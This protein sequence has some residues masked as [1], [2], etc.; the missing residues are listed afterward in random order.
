[1]G[2]EPGRQV[3]GKERVVA[4]CQGGA[5]GGGPAG[6]GRSLPAGPASHTTG[7]GKGSSL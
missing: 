7:P 6:R 1:M 4:S 5:R 3:S 2:E